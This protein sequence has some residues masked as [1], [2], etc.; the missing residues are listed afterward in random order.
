M[1]TARRRRQGTRCASTPG[2]PTSRSSSSGRASR[3]A[4]AA[5]AG[6]PT[7]A[8]VSWSSSADPAAAGDG[9]LAGTTA[10]GVYDHGLVTAVQRRPVPG[11][12]GRLWRIRARR[13]SSSRRAP[14]NARSCSPTTTGRDHA[15]VGRRDLH[16]SASASGRAREPSCSPRTTRHATSRPAMAG[17]GVEVVAVV[18]ARR[19]EFVTGTDGDADG[20]RRLRRRPDDRRPG[21]GGPAARIRWLEPERR[22]VGPRPRHAALRRAHRG[23]RPGRATADRGR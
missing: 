14:R 22:P 23:L 7:R 15:R 11:T 18:D 13:R 5:V 20:R 17:A 19:G 1:G 12:E 3:A 4:A 8:P 16:P 9:V 2:T 6:R 21:R 10:L